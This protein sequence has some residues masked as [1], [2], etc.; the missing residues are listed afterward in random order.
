MDNIRSYG[1]D[2]RRVSLVGHS[3][4]AQLCASA[5]TTRGGEERAI[6]N[7]RAR[8]SRGFANAAT[9][10]WHRGS[11]RYRLSLRLRRLEESPS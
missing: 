3:A 5:V 7:E 6:E 8:V 1:G 10:R 11:V 9:I 2:A 4:G